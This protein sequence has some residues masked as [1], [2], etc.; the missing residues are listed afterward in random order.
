MYVYIM[1]QYSMMYI[2]IQVHHRSKEIWNGSLRKENYCLYT[3]RGDA[4]FDNI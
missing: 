2:K 4:E 1:I 3:R